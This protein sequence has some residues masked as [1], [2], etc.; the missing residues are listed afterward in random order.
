M[1]LYEY[2]GRIRRVIDGDTLEIEADLGFHIT[3]T[4]RVRLAGINAPE[5]RGDE[6]EAGRASKAALE[7]FLL[8]GEAVRPVFGYP[9]ILHTFKGRSF[10]RW[11]ASVHV[12]PD[13]NG[14]PVSVA[15]WMVENGHAEVSER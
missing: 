14:E 7:E 10:G 11:V 13:P 12:M 6:R 3:K 5:V 2:K 9:C 1:A 15:D 4:I 8:A